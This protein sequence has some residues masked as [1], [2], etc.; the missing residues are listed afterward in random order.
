MAWGV[1]LGM[2][3]RAAGGGRV[4]PSEDQMVS[5]GGTGGQGFPG[6]TLVVELAH[7]S[8]GELI[9]IALGKGGGGGRGGSGFE[10]GGDGG[11]GIDG[12]V[13]FVPVFGSGG[14]V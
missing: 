9:E 8:E 6:E 7:L 5:D 3:E 12:S 4:E 1:V 10:V 13:I 14:N 2:V 11:K